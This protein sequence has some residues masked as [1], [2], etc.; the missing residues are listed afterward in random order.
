MTVR[1]M[2]EQFEIQ[3]ALK[4]QRLNDK[5][6]RTEVLYDIDNHENDLV[7]KGYN[8]LDK[9]ITYMY[10]ITTYDRYNFEIP[11]IVIEIK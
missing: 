7:N 11:Q 6:D 10:S 3:G 4:I 8:W 9:E 5:D 1:D 2:L